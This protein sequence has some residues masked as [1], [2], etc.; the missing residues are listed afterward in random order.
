MAALTEA[1]TSRTAKAGDITLHYNEAG[2]GDTLIMIHGGGPGAS[3]WSNFRGNIGPLSEHFRVLLV[4]MPGFGKSDKPHY[5]ES[6]GAYTAR[7][8]KNLMDVLN[9][10][11]AHFIGNSLGGHS[12]LK[13]A[14]DYPDRAGRLVAMAPATA[15]FVNTTAPSPPEGVRLLMSYY[16]PPGPSVEKLKA[17]IQTLVYDSSWLT[18][19]IVK[20][21]F[22]SSIKPDIVSWT[23]AVMARPHHIEPFWTEFDKIAHP[24]LLVWG[25]DDRV[26]PLDGS[27]FMLQRMKNAQLHVYPRCGHWAMVERPAEFNSLC[28]DFLR[29][30]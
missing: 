25:R 21:R 4:D 17:F 24:T 16:R 28:L 19:D 14:L 30:K 22:E 29:Q 11:K 26:V 20:E 12:A 10:P 7:A 1:G 18:D 13:F 3:G 23:K 15:N 8:I 27:L 5:S 9:I 2:N 6:H